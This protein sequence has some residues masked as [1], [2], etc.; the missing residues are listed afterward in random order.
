MFTHGFDLLG[1]NTD[2]FVVM[3]VKLTAGRVAPLF[4]CG[5]G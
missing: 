5:D 4:L 1:V 3:I 2:P